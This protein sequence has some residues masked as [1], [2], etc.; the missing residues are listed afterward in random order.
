MK[1]NSPW[2]QGCSG[3]V[4]ELAADSGDAD[5]DVFAV[6]DESGVGDVRACLPLVVGA[7]IG[8]EPIGKGSVP[9]CT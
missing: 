1:P 4:V 7:S 5:V 9:F 3:E 6:G 8:E 2:R